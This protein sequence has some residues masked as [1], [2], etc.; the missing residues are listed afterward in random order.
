MVVK[1]ERLEMA[2]FKSL[3]EFVLL[4]INPNN[5]KSALLVTKITYFHLTS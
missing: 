4:D 3:V 1:I 5:F 2:I